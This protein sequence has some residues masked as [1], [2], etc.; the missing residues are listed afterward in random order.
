M[1]MEKFLLI[2]LCVKTMDAAWSGKCYVC[3]SKE[4]E[5]NWAITGLPTI[6]GR[7]YNFDGTLRDPSKLSS[8]CAGQY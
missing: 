6:T 4:L 5:T 3:A 7:N 8:V 2:A 1:M